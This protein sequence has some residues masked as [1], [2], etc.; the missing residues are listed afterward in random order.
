MERQQVLVRRGEEPGVPVR[1]IANPSADVD[2]DVVGWARCSPRSTSWSGPTTS[3]PDAWSTPS[4]CPRRRRR[5]APRRDPGRLAGGGHV[6]RGQPT[7]KPPSCSAAG[8]RPASA[9]PSSCWTGAGAKRFSSM[10]TALAER[11]VRLEDPADG[12]L[13]V[14]VGRAGRDPLTCR[15]AQSPTL[16]QWTGPAADL[17]TELTEATSGPARTRPQLLLGAGVGV[18]GE[19]AVADPDPGALDQDVLPARR[20]S[21]PVRGLRVG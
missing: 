21:L 4:A 19:R 6:E 9:R 1:V 2:A 17:G 13:P 11:G 5:G 15:S 14:T 18:E 8:W 20:Q 12:A 16:R 10:R 7:G 3:R